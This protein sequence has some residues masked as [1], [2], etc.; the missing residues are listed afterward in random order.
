MIDNLGCFVISSSGLHLHSIVAIAKLGE[1][2]AADIVQ[3]VDPLQELFVVPLCAQLQDGAAE[4]VE[5]NRHLGRHGR[6]DDSSELVSCKDSQW[7]VPEVLHRDKV[8]VTDPL[9]P[10][11]GQVSLLLQGDVV[12][13]HHHRLRDE[14]PEVCPHLVVV[15]VEQGC[16]LRDGE[17]GGEQLGSDLL[18][19]HCVGQLH[20]GGRRCGVATSSD[21]HI[22][23][24]H[25]FQQ[26]GL[27]LK[28]VDLKTTVKSLDQAPGLMRGQRW[29]L[30][31]EQRRD[32]RPLA[33]KASCPWCSPDPPL[34]VVNCL[35]FSWPE[36]AKLYS[37]M[38][39]HESRRSY[40]RCDD[41]N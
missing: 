39:F 36:L 2:E 38:R 34:Q 10:P 7:V 33:L 27:C 35:E 12:P 29:P 20:H 19:G 25:L 9:K 40:E 37:G 28:T 32:E 6:V 21:K 31:Q 24:N 11:E 41:C 23:L 14:L 15:M 26:E 4:Q 17:A 1:P 3:V 13:R 8:V 30:R 22:F 5:L 18:W 16:H